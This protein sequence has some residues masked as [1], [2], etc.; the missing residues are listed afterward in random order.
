M[1]SWEVCDICLLSILASISP[2][3]DLAQRV[4]A[5][6]DFRSSSVNHAYFA[7]LMEELHWIIMQSS[8]IVGFN[9]HSSYC[10]ASVNHLS[11]LCPG[12]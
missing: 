12:W 9:C 7:G 11:I 10:H 6:L 4:L 3:C 8:V 5:S 1:E 2:L